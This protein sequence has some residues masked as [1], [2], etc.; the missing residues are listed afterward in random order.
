M[1]LFASH[2]ERAPQR[3]RQSYALRLGVAQALSAVA[4]GWILGAA[5]GLIGLVD[6]AHPFVSHAGAYRLAVHAMSASFGGGD[7]GAG[8]MRVGV[9]LWG[10]L[11]ATVAAYLSARAA[12]KR[13]RLPMLKDLVVSQASAALTAGFLGALGAVIPSLDGIGPS[14]SRAFFIA[15]TL[16][17]VGGVLAFLRSCDDYNTFFWRRVRRWWAWLAPHLGACG[18]FLLI[19]SAGSLATFLLTLALNGTRW[20]PLEGVSLALAGPNAAGAA[21]LAATGGSLTLAGPDLTPV[22]VFSF[23][24]YLDGPLVQAIATGVVAAIAFVVATARL[25]GRHTHLASACL[26]TAFVW[27]V[28][29]AV[30]ASACALGND[31]EWSIRA[32][33]LGVWL[34][35]VVGAAACANAI[36]LDRRAAKRGQPEQG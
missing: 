26:A 3:F 4:A 1:P 25:R 34:T 32:G 21:A 6:G 16:T 8:H 18:R 33:H 23:S 13:R 20:T 28:C 9:F 27:L 22:A 5:S 14:G 17:C 15:A 29:A 11:A 24:P 7:F 10:A 35:G 31:G 30:L 12:L 2:D 19:T 36:L